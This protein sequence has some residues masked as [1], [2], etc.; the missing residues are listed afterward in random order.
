MFFVFSEVYM[1]TQLKA[2]LQDM[3]THCRDQKS[4]N[5]FL[6]LSRDYKNRKWRSKWKVQCK[7]S[8]MQI[9]A[10]ICNNKDLPKAEMR[11][12]WR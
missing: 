6:Q 9:H 4:Q 1:V 5:D 3:C 8:R 10:V 2:L 12:T 7:R 11:M